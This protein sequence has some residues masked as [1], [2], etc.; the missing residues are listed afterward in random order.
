MTPYNTVEGLIDRYS[1]AD[2][3]LMIGDICNAKAEYI[4]TMYQDGLLVGR[5]AKSA[6][7]VQQAV[8]ELPKVPGIK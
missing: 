3:L 8:K 1:L 4:D 2:V 6:R 5:W 7:I